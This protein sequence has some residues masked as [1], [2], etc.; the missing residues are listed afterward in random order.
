[1]RLIEDHEVVLEQHPAIHVLLKATQQSETRILD[2]IKKDYDVN[3]KTTVLLGNSFSDSIIRA[4][5]EHDLVIFGVT[6][7]EHNKFKNRIFGTEDD[8][9][10]SK[11]ACSVLKVQSSRLDTIK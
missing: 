9:I 4:S 7:R 10:T 6:E 5:A 1:M 11:A 2:D 3:W 8:R